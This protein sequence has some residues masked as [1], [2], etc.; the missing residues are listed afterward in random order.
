MAKGIINAFANMEFC[1]AINL[2]MG[3]NQ[4]SHG[5]QYLLLG[6]LVLL[7]PK[8]P[9]SKNLLPTEKGNFKH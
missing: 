1:L 2:I 6:M 9:G 5:L 3:G 7:L 8:I 4:A